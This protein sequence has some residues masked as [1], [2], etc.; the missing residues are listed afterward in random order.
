[1][2]HLEENE[3]VESKVAPLQSVFVKKSQRRSAHLSLIRNPF[4]CECHLRIPPGQ[5][6]D[7]DETLFME[8][9]TVIRNTMRWDYSIP[10]VSAEQ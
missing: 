7:I 8:N 2:R 6:R 1:M 10:F 4:L 3:I 5:A 9:G